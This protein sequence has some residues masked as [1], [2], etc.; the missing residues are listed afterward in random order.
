[1]S[2]CTHE[3][4]SCGESCGERCAPQD[5]RKQPHQLSHIRKVIGI[6]SGKG[7][8]GKSLVTS[9]LACLAQKNGYKTAVLDADITGPSIPKMF[10]INERASAT[11]LGLIPATSR[12][13]IDIMSLNLL[14]ESENQPVI[15]RGAVISSVVEQFWTEVI[16]GDVDFMF[17][18]MPPGTG[19]VPLTVFQS[20]PVDGIIIVASPQELVN[21]IV[22]KAVNMA[23]MM[24]IP[25]LGMVENMSYLRCPD[26]G[27]EIKVFGE[28][29]VEETA[30]EYGIPLIGRIPIDPGIASLCDKGRVEEADSSCLASFTDILKAL[31]EDSYK[32]DMTP[33]KIAVSHKDGM[34]FDHF[35]HSEEF[36]IY[37]FVGNDI[38]AQEVVKTNGQGHGAIVGFLKEQGVGAVICGGIGGGA[39]SA[40]EAERIFVFGGVTGECDKVI[41]QWL[42]GTLQYDPDIACAH[43]ENGEYHCGSDSPCGSCGGCH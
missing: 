33:F 41:Q 39:R 1:M 16:W 27:K 30:A 7:G 25:I 19:D 20:L 17:V 32:K 3:C 28:S 10:G 37:T 36:K 5:M 21:M 43:H 14:L 35:G 24:D 22:E 6:V 11:E 26:C 8:V 18:D 15:W 2:E 34:V 9:M 4:G 12:N 31:H 38:S 40:L 23:N 42:E 29:H 13:D